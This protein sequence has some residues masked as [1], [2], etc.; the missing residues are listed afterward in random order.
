MAVMKEWRDEFD[1]RRTFFCER[2]D[3][4]EGI[5]CHTFEGAFYAF[6]DVSSFGVPIQ[7]FVRELLEK[8]NVR[9]ANGEKFGGVGVVGM[10]SP[11]FGHIRPCLV[12][13]VE[14]LGEAADRI[15]RYVKSL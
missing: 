13:D 12:Q 14:V 15:E 11:A 1:K 10:E 6:P 9:V 8:E 5:S 7:R 3:E 2:M 4:I